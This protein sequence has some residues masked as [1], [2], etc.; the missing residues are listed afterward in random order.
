MQYPVAMIPYANT[1]PYKV[2]GVPARCRFVDMVP[3]KS[4]DAITKAKVWA[5]AVPVGGLAEL[6]GQIDFLGN[7]GI[8]TN[9]RSRSVLLFSDKP[10]DKLNRQTS[11][12]LTDQS[13]TSV[14]LLYLLL[15]YRNGFNNLPCVTEEEE[16]ANGKLLIGDEA[17]TKIIAHDQNA[18]DKFTARYPFVTDLA[19]EWHTVH[20]CSFVFARWVIRKDAPQSVLVAILNWLEKFRDHEKE[21][22]LQSSKVEAGRLGISEEE[23]FNYLFSIK[24]VLNEEDIKGQTLFQEEIKHKAQTPLFRTSKT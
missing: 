3:R 19:K 4:I 8:A 12:H 6:Q 20:R 9:G 1:G 5:A 22:L 18:N 13:V 23:M 17:L 2:A 21:F 24:R 7:F 14:R 15:G 11:I 10:F 16:Q